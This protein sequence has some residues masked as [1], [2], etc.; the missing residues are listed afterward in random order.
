MARKATFRFNASVDTEQ[1]GPLKE[2]CTSEYA[3]LEVSCPYAARMGTRSWV[4]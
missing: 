4:G 2:Q 1:K 3:S